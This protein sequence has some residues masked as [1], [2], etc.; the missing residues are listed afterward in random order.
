[1]TNQTRDALER[2]SREHYDD[3]TYYDYTYRTRKEDIAFYRRLARQYGGPVL[4]I[5]GGSGRVAIPIAADGC[6]VTV[7]DSNASMLARA[8]AQANATLDVPTRSRVKLVHGDMRAFR[9]PSRKFALVIAP[10]IVLLH[11]YEPR[12]FAR[13]FQ[14]ISKHLARDARFVFDV[15]VPIPSELARNPDRV[16]K[17]RPFR[18]PTY[19]YRVEYSERFHYDPIKQVQHVTMRFSPARPGAP[20]SARPVEVL[21]TQRQIFP[22]ELRALLALG[23]LDLDRRCGDFTGRPLS[24]DDSQE[25]VFARKAHRAM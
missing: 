15:R 11:L 9:F 12:D 8:R 5:G 4:E 6:D 22:N 3:A 2:G 20:R 10:F 21:L 13:C 24:P 25:I 1:M 14:C 17:S 23:G 7:L 16:Y 19:G 18:H